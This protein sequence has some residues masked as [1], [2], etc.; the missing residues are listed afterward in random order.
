MKLKNR[1]VALPRS[2]K[3]FLSANLLNFTICQ[4]TKWISKGP[5]CAEEFLS[6]TTKDK[7]SLQREPHRGNNSIIS[8]V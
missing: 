5:S 6:L 8:N 2:S 7:S 1:G 3:F 4:G